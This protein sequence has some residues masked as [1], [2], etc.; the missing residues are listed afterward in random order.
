MQFPRPIRKTYCPS[1]CEKRK[2]KKEKEKWKE[3]KRKRT[4]YWTSK[5]F[6]LSVF[7]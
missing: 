2:K 5:L 7:L 1:I 3:M 4:L 6:F